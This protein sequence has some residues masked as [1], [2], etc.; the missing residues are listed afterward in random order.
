MHTSRSRGAHSFEGCKTCRKR[1]L[2]CDQTTPRCRRC[3]L[4]GLECDFK[5]AL[6][7]VVVAGP[8]DC[9]TSV[10]PTNDASQYSRRHLYSEELREVMSTSLIANLPSTV[11]EALCR[12][13][14][15][16]KSAEINKDMILTVGPFGVFNGAYAAED[17]KPKVEQ[18]A[19]P[20]IAVAEKCT[21]D[22]PPIISFSEGTVSPF[23]ECNPMRGNNDAAT[24]ISGY[25]GPNEND[26]T[27][28]N[29]LDELFSDSLD[30][31]Q[32]GDLFTWDI[33]V[34]NSPQPSYSMDCVSMTNQPV[35]DMLD[36]W[37]LCETTI[38]SQTKDTRES[39]SIQPGAILQPQEDL[40]VDAPLLLRHFYDEV[41][42]QMGSLPINE[43]SAWRILNF[44][45]AIVTLSQ[46]TILGLSINDIRHAN[47]S[48]LYAIIAVSAF[49]LSLNSDNFPELAK[50]ERYW[51]S[52]SKRTYEC[53]KSQLKLSFEEE[54]A[55][56]TKAKYKEQLMAAAAILAT[57]LLSGNE[58]DT[59]RYLLEME[60]LIRVR[61]LRKSKLS[62]RARL[63]HNIYA[64]MRIVSES[65]KTFH[66]EAP[67]LDS[68]S[69]NEVWVTAHD[70][71]QLGTASSRPAIPSSESLR[72]GYPEITL[73]NF[74]HLEPFQ[75]HPDHTSGRPINVDVPLTNK[76]IHLAS[77]IQDQEDMYMQIYGV[78]ET[79]LRLVSQITRLANVMDHL[80]PKESQPDAIKM[81]ALQPKASYLEEAVCAFRARYDSQHEQD[82]ADEKPHVH[83]VRALS[84]AL[85]IFFYRRIRK[86]NPM[87]LQESVDE[88]MEALQAFD[89]ALSR[90]KLL[91]PGTAWPAFIA[92]AE[93]TKPEKREQFSSWLLKAH[94]KS[95]WKGYCVSREVLREVW[96][97]QDADYNTSRRS[98][99]VDVCRANRRW[100]LLC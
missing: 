63:L 8:D 38:N 20:N 77:S 48:N 97:N 21:T 40:V 96:R 35:C 17:G 14:D 59:C 49:H 93:A 28:S 87:L 29:A 30:F 13:E 71:A 32:W 42:N 69:I 45:S 54:S 11:T 44:P 72:K 86:I 74:L 2:K 1:H 34:N 50:P 7:W 78:P 56:P 43:K 88:V 22:D 92:G 79:W 4:S 26:F 25:S 58:Q 39:D 83:M 82:L 51:M 100:P 85:M 53:A 70:Q 6:R 52:L 75:L 68:K 67:I 89:E 98:T 16:T 91:G 18:G 80:A 81:A 95:G 5:A 61:G 31:L 24:D 12:I 57:A 41:I 94:A 47:L 99:W 9:S 46:L 19:K 66:D 90:N 33:E 10:P 65:T 15:M 23:T 60:R 3:C 27:M 36:G 62:R 73:D 84:P 37:T 55:T 76:D 64:W